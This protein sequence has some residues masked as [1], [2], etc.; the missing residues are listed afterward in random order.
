M[1]LELAGFLASIVVIWEFIEKN[2][3]GWFTMADG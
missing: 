1:L 2:T 3:F